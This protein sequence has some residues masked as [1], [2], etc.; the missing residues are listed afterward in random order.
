[1]IQGIPSAKRCRP[2]VSSSCGPSLK[3]KSGPL[4]SLQGI[5]ESLVGGAKGKEGKENKKFEEVL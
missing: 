5:P 2:H 1:M 4:G 3:H